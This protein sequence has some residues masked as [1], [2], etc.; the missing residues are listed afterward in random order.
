MF[1]YPSLIFIIIVHQN[2]DSSS[3]LEFNGFRI[4]KIYL[5]DIFGNFSKVYYAGD[6]IVYYVVA[7]CTMGPWLSTLHI[8]LIYNV[9]FSREEATYSITRCIKAEMSTAKWV[10]IDNYYGYASFTLLVY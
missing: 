4:W 10:T 7:T 9:F 3:T 5:K 6:V 1:I 8:G 2:I